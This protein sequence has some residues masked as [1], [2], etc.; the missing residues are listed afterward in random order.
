MKNNK[1]Q[2]PTLGIKH[3]GLGGYLSILP[4]NKF[5]VT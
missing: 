1:H 4:R 2:L 3:W 5:G